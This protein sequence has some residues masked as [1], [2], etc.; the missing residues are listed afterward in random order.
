MPRADYRICKRCGRSAEEVGPLS[1]TR[2]CGDCGVERR[3]ANNDSIH[4]G[5]GVGHERRRY[6]YARKLFG[7][8]V[9]LAMKQAGIFDASLLDDA[10]PRP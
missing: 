2:L 4:E 9:A 3:D 6:G 1:H 8:R 7:P 5:H 10:P